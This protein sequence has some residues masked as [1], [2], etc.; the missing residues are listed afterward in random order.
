MSEKHEFQLFGQKQLEAIWHLLRG[1]AISTLGTLWNVVRSFLDDLKKAKGFFEKFGVAV[2]VLIVGLITWNSLSDMYGAAYRFIYR[3]WYVQH[4]RGIVKQEAAAFF[5]LY[6]R[7]F[8]ERD[9]DFMRKVGADEAMYD[10]LGR[11]EYAPDSYN[12]NNFYKGIN[13]KYYLPFEIEPIIESFEKRRIR[14]KAIVVRVM[15]DGR[16]IAS[17]QYFEIW[18][19]HD[20]DLWHFNASSKTGSPKIPLETTTQL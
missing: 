3:D 17:A 11:T 1:F 5:D 19:V 12:C 2:A 7:K 6:S 20:W 8:I 10:N 9:C 14:G 15:E 16:H 18:K 4:Y 13:A